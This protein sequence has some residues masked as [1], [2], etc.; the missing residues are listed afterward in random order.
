[1][2][3]KETGSIAHSQKRNHLKLSLN[4]KDIMTDMLDKDG[5]TLVLKMHK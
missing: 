1:M 4:Q 5:Q 3:Y 2:K